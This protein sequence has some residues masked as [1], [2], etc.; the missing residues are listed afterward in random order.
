MADV[1]AYGNAC[2]FHDE[3]MMGSKEHR[4]GLKWDWHGRIG[5]A[6][7]TFLVALIL[8]I[9]A[10]AH[11]GPPFPIIEHKTVGPYVISLWTHP[12]IGTGTFFVIVDPVPGGKV[13]SD[14]KVQIG[15][16]PESG[17]LP[18]KVYD[19]WRDKVRDHVQFDNQVDFDQQDFFRVRLVLQSSI[20]GGEALSRVEATPTGLG[21]WDLL[22]FASPFLL[23]AFLWF[24]GMSKRRKRM[25]KKMASGTPVVS[26]GVPAGANERGKA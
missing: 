1:S 2:Y 19:T 11:N 20:G 22:F 18:E 14:V 24:R 12:D 15:I 10:V 21:R 6:A 17:R 7:A 5:S 26:T 25:K 3:L 23:V 4:T 8:A 9:P 16:Q 13:P